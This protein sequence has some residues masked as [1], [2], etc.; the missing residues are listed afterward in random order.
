MANE[1]NLIPFNELTESQHREIASKG[2]KA[3][4]E[5]KRNKKLLR[6]CLDYL[7]EKQDKDVI[8]DDGAPM[9][10]AEKLAFNL[11]MKALNEIDT[12]KAAKAFEV[13]RDTAGQKPVEKVQSTQTIVDMSKFTTA[14]L[15]GMLD[16]D[17]T[18]CD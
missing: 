15:K 1:Q 3:S 17:I 5:A 16:D 13:L 14:E 6:D 11:Y 9:T 4:V 8:G 12:A 2:G 18:E 7:L 10:G